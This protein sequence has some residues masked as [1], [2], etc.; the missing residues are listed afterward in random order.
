MCENTVTYTYD[1]EEK[2][3]VC[4]ETGY[5]GERLVCFE[6]SVKTLATLIKDKRSLV[7]R[8]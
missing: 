2:F 5:H 6:C 4:G 7:L 8:N 1:D 3:S